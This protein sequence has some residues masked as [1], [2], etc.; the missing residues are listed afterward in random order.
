MAGLVVAAMLRHTGTISPAE[1]RSPSRDF[2][3]NGLKPSTAM[4]EK[5]SMSASH[6]R[7]SPSNKKLTPYTLYMRENYVSLKRQCKDDKRAIFTRCH[8]MWENEN[9]HV[10]RMYERM[11]VEENEE[12]VGSNTSTSNG[13]NDI[14]SSIVDHQSN[15]S[16]DS[17]NRLD[18]ISAE[19]SSTNLRNTSLSLEA[20]VQFASEIAALHIDLNSREL[21]YIDANHLLQRSMLF[22]SAGTQEI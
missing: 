16:N 6:H 9:E 12:E 14:D 7:G 19:G 21:D 3:E 15:I 13:W 5:D 22:S 4:V 1:Q 17:I 18:I 10:K 2:S 8:E 11:A 20:A